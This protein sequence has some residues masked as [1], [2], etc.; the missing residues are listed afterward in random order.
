MTAAVVT[1]GC[2]LNQAESDML[3]A[4]LIKQGVEIVDE[5]DSAEEC[6]VNTCSVTEAADRK[7]LKWVRRAVR[8]GARVV[9]MGCLV[10]ADPRRV[11]SVPGVCEIWN[12][13]RK[14]AEIDGYGPH[15]RRS[16]AFLKVQDGCDAGCTYCRPSRVRRRLWSISP[17]RARAEFVRLLDDGFAEFVIT[18]LNLGRYRG[19]LALLLAELLAVPGDFRLRLASLEPEAFDA[20]LLG[21]FAE[22]RVCPHFHLPLQSGDD[23]LLRRMGR[24]Y[25]TRDFAQLLETLKRIRPDANVGIDIIVGFPGETDRSFRMTRCFIEAMPIDYLH[26]F[27]YSRRLGT[28]VF[29]AVDCVAKHDKQMRVRELID[30][31]MERR[32]RYRTQFTGSIR[33]AVVESSETVLTDNYL[34]LKLLPSTPAQTRSLIRVRVMEDGCS[35][36]EV[37]RPSIVKTAISQRREP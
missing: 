31:D 11:L 3:V 17:E 9:A 27:P 25:T 24:S 8:F 12:S 35:G 10:D 16:R 4:K 34:R 14:Q 26:V 2:R 36:Y 7:S 21:M 6:Y 19:G 18:G 15:P 20:E 22:E 29:D 33:R 28:P 30:I 37:T 13:D 23:A 1:I 5:L 32:V